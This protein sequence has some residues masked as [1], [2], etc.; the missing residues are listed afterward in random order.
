MK[1]KQLRFISKLTKKCCGCKEYFEEN[2]FY[3]KDHYCKACRNQFPKNNRKRT[4]LL[5]GLTYWYSL[6]QNETYTKAEVNLFEQG[7]TTHSN[8]P[9]VFYAFLQLV[10]SYYRQV[11]AE[12]F[13]LTFVY[14]YCQ[15][16]PLKQLA[17]NINSNLFKFDQLQ[18][19]TL[20][21]LSNKHLLGLQVDHQPH[22]GTLPKWLT[23]AKECDKC[24]VTRPTWTIDNLY[25]HSI[26]SHHEV[27]SLVLRGI[28][29]STSL[30]SPKHIRYLDFKPSQYSNDRWKKICNFC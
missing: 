29:S 9:T 26:A 16:E 6:Q 13:N 7:N 4:T 27:F 22:V 23:Y 2:N 11:Y 30:G 28:L 20:V 19:K 24:G 12:A 3:G 5:N 25:P 1:I 14:P 10:P 18:W 15:V 21:I 8:V 17:K